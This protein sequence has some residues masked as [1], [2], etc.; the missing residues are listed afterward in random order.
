MLTNKTDV[1]KPNVF[2]EMVDQQLMSDIREYLTDNLPKV[3]FQKQPN[4][5]STYFWSPVLTVR[6]LVFE[7]FSEKVQKVES[8]NAYQQDIIKF[9]AQQT[10]GFDVP[11]FQSR[12]RI[13][14]EKNENEIAKRLADLTSKGHPEAEYEAWLKVIKNSLEWLNDPIRL[15][16]LSIV[17]NHQQQRFQIEKIEE[18][19]AALLKK[20]EEDKPAVPSAMIA[21]T[22]NE[23]KDNEYR[24]LA[25]K[26]LEFLFQTIVALHVDAAKSIQSKLTYKRKVPKEVSNAMI[27]VITG[28]IVAI[29][30][31][32][33]AFENSDQRFANVGSHIGDLLRDA[34]TQQESLLPTALPS[35]VS[36]V[37]AYNLF[38]LNFV[39]KLA[40]FHEGMK[41]LSP[42]AALKKGQKLFI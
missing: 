36:A 28:K 10:T 4:A 22:E 40:E 33:H 3:E 27:F 12:I 2:Q 38:M 25:S 16:A 19:R 21:P 26:L 18:E 17:S 42:A 30:S 20:A 39:E 6:S 13:L 7:D 37:I 29:D 24:K 35:M 41:N 32:C 15:A 31:T 14:H 11:S 1:V 9:A 5:V 23:L 8:A 34:E